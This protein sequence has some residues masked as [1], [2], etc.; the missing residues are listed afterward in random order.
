L[1]LGALIVFS[2]VF[3]GRVSVAICFC[4]FLSIAV[5]TEGRGIVA[6]VSFKP[7]LSLGRKT[8]IQQKENKTE[9]IIEMKRKN[10]QV[11]FKE[12]DRDAGG[13]LEVD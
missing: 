8:W 1:I 11:S 9:E 6:A 12:V 10:L 3:F 2:R 13:F 7:S 5:E 4:E